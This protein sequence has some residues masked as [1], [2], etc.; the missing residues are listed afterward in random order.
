MI[1]QDSDIKLTEDTGMLALS[2]GL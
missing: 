1:T 2:T